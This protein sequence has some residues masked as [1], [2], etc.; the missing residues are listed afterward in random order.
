MIMSVP[1]A[2]VRLILCCVPFTLQCLSSYRLTCSSSLAAHSFNCASPDFHRSS[3]GAH[4][5]PSS[6]SPYFS[7]ALI[8]RLS[9]TQQSCSDKLRSGR[10]T[11]WAQQSQASSCKA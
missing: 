8:L 1:P 3:F 11:V 2:G 5:D 6:A 4:Q 10:G 7:F 9:P